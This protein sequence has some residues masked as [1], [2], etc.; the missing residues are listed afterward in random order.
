MAILDLQ[1]LALEDGALHDA[2][3]VAGG[4]A[5]EA[6]SA[7]PF[8]K[9]GKAIDLAVAPSSWSGRLPDSFRGGEEHGRLPT[10]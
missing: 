7:L 2:A 1:G 8:A 9:Q 5:A 6:A 3:G 4:V 10:Q